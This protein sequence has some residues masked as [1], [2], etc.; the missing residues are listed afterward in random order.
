MGQW[1]LSQGLGDSAHVSPTFDPCPLVIWTPTNS[2]SLLGHCY[3][4]SGGSVSGMC[5]TSLRSR[6]GRQWLS[7]PWTGSVTGL[8]AGDWG[9]Y[10]HIQHI[11][12][13]MHG[14]TCLWPMSGISILHWTLQITQPR[15][16]IVKIQIQ[17]CPT[18]RTSRSRTKDS[19]SRTTISFP[20]LGRMEE[21]ALRLESEHLTLIPGLSFTC[22]T[23]LATKTNLSK[24]GNH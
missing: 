22:C 9:A 5:S 4:S 14:S 6:C 13:A 20:G 1:S 12:P 16:S 8:S 21:K 15:L 18:S 24:P 7:L 3:L 23:T 19:W 11:P 17:F 10:S 2:L